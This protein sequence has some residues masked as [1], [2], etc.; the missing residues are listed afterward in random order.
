MA[1]KAKARPN[2]YQ[3][4]DRKNVYVGGINILPWSRTT[5]S[6]NFYSQNTSEA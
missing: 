6:A 1:L 2:E 5:L 4:D 3:Q